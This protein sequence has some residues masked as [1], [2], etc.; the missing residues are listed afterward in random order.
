MRRLEILGQI[1]VIAGWLLVAAGFIGVLIAEGTR[2]LVPPVAFLG[3]LIILL[4]FQ[5]REAACGKATV[6][7]RL[8]E[9]GGE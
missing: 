8:N 5:L 1:A 2:D 6:M 3:V 7:G 9:K 4:G